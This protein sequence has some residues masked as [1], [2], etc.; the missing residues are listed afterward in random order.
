MVTR[1]NSKWLKVIVLVAVFV[2]VLGGG[3]SFR[4]WQ[5]HEAHSDPLGMDGDFDFSLRPS[6]SG[7]PHWHLVWPEEDT[8]WCIHAWKLSFAWRSLFISDL[9]TLSS[10]Q[11]QAWMYSCKLTLDPEIYGE[12]V[13]RDW[14]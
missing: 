10:D 1:Y 3:Y 4:Y 6:L 13:W 14:E 11:R 5:L 8:L 7:E 12:V 9:E 2:G